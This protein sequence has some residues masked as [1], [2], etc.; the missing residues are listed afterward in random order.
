MEGAV[1]AMALMAEMRD[2]Y[3]A[4]HE[5]GVTH[6][7]VALAREMELPDDQ[8]EGLRL[9]GVVHDI[10]KIGVPT[11]ILSRPGRITE[12]EFSIIKTHPQVSYNIL[13]A[14]DFPWPVAQITLQ[15][16]E[17]WDGS[18]YP[19]GLKGEKILLEA[20][21][22]GVADVVHAMACHRPY[23]AALGIEKALEEISSKRGALYDPNVVDAC[24]VL[25]KDKGFR[26]EQ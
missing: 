19:Q 15:H 26:F 7:A 12:M 9:A 10:G 13:K 25:F 6:L 14:I 16:H 18:G 8:I 21:I 4:G 1:E 2:P 5:R 23:R 3:T 20:R 11:E 22:L 17:R 24:I